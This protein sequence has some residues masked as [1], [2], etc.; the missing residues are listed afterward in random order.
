[1]DGLDQE[2]IDDWADEICSGD[3]SDCEYADPNGLG[4]PEYDQFDDDNGDGYSGGDI[5]DQSSNSGN[6]SGITEGGHNGGDG[7][8][9]V[10]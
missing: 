10:I 1:V 7:Y 3:M 2:T 8:I 5:A 6:S 4:S 9:G